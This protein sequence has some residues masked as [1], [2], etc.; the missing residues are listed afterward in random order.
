MLRLEASGCC[1][2]Q[3]V[4]VV[5]HDPE[6][7]GGVVDS[8]HGGVAVPTEPKSDQG[9]AVTPHNQPQ[10]RQPPHYA[11]VEDDFDNDFYHERSSPSK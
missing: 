1:A 2:L 8:P 3:V 7:L 10:P 4:Q 5:D 11:P 9:R 6:G